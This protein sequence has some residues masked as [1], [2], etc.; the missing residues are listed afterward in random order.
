MSQGEEIAG[1]TGLKKPAVD[2]KRSSSVFGSDA[3]QN[4]QKRPK[5]NEYHIL[6]S[7]SEFLSV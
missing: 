4:S 2:L 1:S 7:L 3:T 6:I 5:V